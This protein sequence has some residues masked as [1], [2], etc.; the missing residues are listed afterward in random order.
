M[1][2]VIKIFIVPPLFFGFNIAQGTNLYRPAKS[3]Y[4]RRMTTYLGIA[5]IS[6][7]ML[8]LELAL[9]RLFAVQQFYHFA[10]MAIS[11]ALLGAGASGSLLSVWPRR[12]AP[13]VLCLSFSLVALGAYLVINYLPF[14]SFSIAWD[15][16]QVFYLAIYFLAAA[17]PFL[18]VGLL[19]GGEL[20]AAGSGAGSHLVYGANLIG[21]AL[22]SVASLPALAAFGG[23]GVVVLAVIVGSAAGLLF[24]RIAPGVWR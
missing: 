6:A 24:S 19:V 10:F 2:K 12:R 17:A 11:L 21:S 14:D 7:A 9:L 23:E 18:F 8:M 13:A 1:I 5:L 4:S 22:G 16:R 3:R 15:R 20:A